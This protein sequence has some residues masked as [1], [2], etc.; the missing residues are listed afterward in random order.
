MKYV[1]YSNAKANDEMKIFINIYETILYEVIFTIHPSHSLAHIAMHNAQHSARENFTSSLILSIAGK[2]Y[3]Y[4]Y[5]LNVHCRGLC[6]GFT[7]YKYHYHSYTVRESV[8]YVCVYK[9]KTQQ[10]GWWLWWWRYDKAI[11]IME[12]WLGIHHQLSRFPIVPALYVE[13]I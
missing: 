7:R 2:S 9:F 5:R 10:V 13:R 6:Q 4:E 8:F 11:N 1:A 12:Q 3:V